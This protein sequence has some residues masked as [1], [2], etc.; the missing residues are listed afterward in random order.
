MSNASTAR[1]W[2]RAIPLLVIVAALLLVSVILIQQVAAQDARTLKPPFRLIL[3][4]KSP[5][6]SSGIL[7]PIGAPIIMSQTFDSTYQPVGDPSQMGWH[8]L[9]GSSAVNGYTWARTDGTLISNTVWSAQLAPA[10]SV[11]LDPVTDTYTNGM[12]ALLV[13]GPIDLSDYHTVILSATY[14]LDTPANGD[15]YGVTVSTDGSNFKAPVWQTNDDASLSTSHTTIYNLSELAAKQP[16]VWI[17]VYFVSNEDD[18]NARG[19][20]L[21]QVVLRAVPLVKTYLPVMAKNYPPTPTPT[22]TPQASVKQWTFGA[23]AANDADFLEWGGGKTSNCGT[24]CEYIQGIVAGGYPDGAMTIYLTG[25]NI[26]GAT[27]PGHVA[28]FNYELSANFNVFNGQKNARYSFIF[29]ASPGTFDPNGTPPFSSTG[30]YYKLEVKMSGIDRNVIEKMQLHQCPDGNCNAISP[31]VYLNSSIPTGQ[32]HTISIQQQNNTITANVNGQ[33]LS[34]AYDPTWPTNRR[35]FG[36]YLETRSNNN[37]G[38]PF[39]IFFDNVR[40]SQL[41]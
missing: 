24:S 32:W 16:V 37:S 9:V 39:E 21:Q 41:P 22:A 25:F 40:L 10:S 2:R 12:E 19:A 14:W 15:Y 31:E 26:A 11:Q 27:T 1:F 29:N 38:G 34:A 8:Q 18:V 35:K 30:D 3:S 6:A 17:G 36:V 28:A 33:T 20:F 7:P 13:Y 4:D 23:G 5:R